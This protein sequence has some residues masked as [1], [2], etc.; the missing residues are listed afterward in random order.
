MSCAGGHVTIVIRQQDPIIQLGA[1]QLTLWVVTFFD[2]LVET[3]AF[4]DGIAALT[5][6]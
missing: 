1:T 3:A 2:V 4:N 5:L 6:S